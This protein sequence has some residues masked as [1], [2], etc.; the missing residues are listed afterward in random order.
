[1]YQR[2]NIFEAI[3]NVPIEYVI[4]K[5]VPLRKRGSSY[6][7]PCPFHSHANDGK[8]SSSFSVKPKGYG[9]YNKGLFRCFA[10]GVKGDVVDYFCQRYGM[11]AKEAA[12]QV[13][14]Y[15]GVITPGEAA[16]LLQGKEISPKECEP[17]YIPEPILSPLASIDWRDKVYKAFINACAPLTPK[18]TELLTKERKIPE[19]QLY[20]Y[21]LFPRKEEVPMIMNK[22][23][24]S[25]QLKDQNELLGIP[26]FFQDRRGKIVFT[27]AKGEAIGIAIF[28]RDHK[29]SGIQLR[30]TSAENGRYKFMS[31][32]FANGLKK[33][34]GSLGSVCGFVEDV[35]YPQNSRHNSIAVTEG[36]FKAE[37][38]VQLGFTVVNMHSISNWKPAGKVARELAG[39][40]KRFVLCYDC[41][42]NPAVW[43]SASNL[44]HLLQD[45]KPVEF[46]VWDKKYGKGIDDVVNSGNISRIKRVCP[47]EY[48]AMYQFN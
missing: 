43:E 48:F 41:E 2:F 16:D 32:G 45:L 24:S 42:D 12:V 20:K 27:Y 38:L 22:I 46:A 23:Q 29:V 31:S 9:R 37:A 11:E 40:A 6:V 39:N 5:D 34:P 35:L 1:M 28:D 3:E 30:Y 25:L 7:G 14:L 33:S 8:Q 10:C 36:R 44:Y 26:G 17:I 19:K 4:G 15:A 13:G 47:E 18:L 21:F